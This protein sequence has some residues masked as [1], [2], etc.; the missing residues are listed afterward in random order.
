MKKWTKS[1]SQMETEKDEAS[2]SL[3]ELASIVG[4]K[5][6]HAL[7]QAKTAFSNLWK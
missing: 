4:E 3:D 7:L 1:E 6:R 5:S 2:K